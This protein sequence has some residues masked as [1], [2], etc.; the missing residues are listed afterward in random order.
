ML[1]NLSVCVLLLISVT[2]GAQSFCSH[3]KPVHSARVKKSASADL[4]ADSFEVQHYHINLDIT[5]FVG[6]SISGYTD[7]KIKSKVNG[8]QTVRLDLLKLSI[9]SI[10][11]GATSLNYNFNDTVLLVDIGNIRNVGDTFTLRVNYSGKPQ[12]DKQWGGFYFS[13]TFAF[14]MGVGFDANPHNFGRVWFPCVDDFKSRS[15]YEYTITTPATYRAMCNGLLQSEIDNGNGTKTWHW[16]LSNNIPTYLSSVAVAPYSVVSDVYS[17][18]NGNTPILLAGGDTNKLKGS[19]IHLKG[20]FAAFEKWYGVHRFER[21]GFNGVP[22]NAGAM[23][24]ATNIAYPLYAIDG[25]ANEETLMAHEFSHHWWGNNA[26]CQTAE[27]MWLNEGWASYSE[28]LFLEEIYGKSTYKQ[29][30]ANNHLEVLRWAH[31]RDGQAW[32]VSGVPHAYTYGAHVYKKGSDVAHTLRGYMGDAD[33]MAGIKDY[34]EKYK[35]TT[36]TTKDLK[37]VLQQQTTANLT[38]FFDNWVYTAGFPAFSAYVVNVVNNSGSYTC[39]VKVHQQLRF[40]NKLY[41]DMPLSITIVGGDG[42]YHVQNITLSQADTQI[43]ITSAIKPLMVVVD[44]DEKI[45]DAVTEKE[46]WVRKSNNYSYSIALASVTTNANTTT[47]STLLRIEHHFSA[48]VP[49]SIPYANLHASGSRYWRVMGTW[50]DSVLNASMGIQYDGTTP[51]G[52]AT[53][54]LDND[55][56]K[57]TEDS[58][59][60]LYRP[61]ASA[62]WVIYPYYQKTAGNVNDKRGNITL[63]G[64]KKGEYVFAMYDRS[65]GIDKPHKGKTQGKLNIYPNPANGLVKIEFDDVY[66]ETQLNI[67]DQAGRTI[68][69]TTLYA[70]QNFVEIDTLNW[71]AGIYYVS[72]ANN[73]KKLVVE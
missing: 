27:D 58:L 7:L 68:Q 52:F 19:F 34:Q 5:D 46:I 43:V 32:P 16:K 54:W 44:R 20:A 65:L 14:N 45:S 17:G 62:D 38:A 28:N 15:T 26:T 3:F 60:L 70:G 21:V 49:S 40:T 29:G 56:I 63:N 73:S 55:I 12:K 69:N 8:L 64:I 1:R 59:V 48:P 53:G 13:G 4:R 41:K 33:F 42:N 39:T 24:H 30:V 50:T 61:N 72:I 2:V 51:G 22:F 23:E 47:D 35:Y 37:D 71:K 67:T 11:I 57:T 18:L 6:Q 10:T 66:S 9:S 36:A 25:T 31:L